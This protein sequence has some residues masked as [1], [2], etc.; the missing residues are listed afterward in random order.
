MNKLFLIGFVALIVLAGFFVF[1][2]TITGQGVVVNAINCTETDGG[3][4]YLNQGSILGTFS[5]N[6]TNGTQSWT[7]IV[8]DT[9]INNVTLSEGVCGSSVSS[10][11][12]NLAGVFSVDCS[13]PNSAYGCVNGAC[14][15]VGT[16]RTNATLRAD[17]IVSNLVY[18]YVSNGTVT[19]NGTNLTSYRVFVNATIRNVGNV[20]AVA[21]STRMMLSKVGEPPRIST[22]SVS[23]PTLGVGQST[24]VSGILT[25]LKGLNLLQADADSSN[26]IVE[27]NEAN[28]VRVVNVTLP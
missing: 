27:S 9:C 16:N 13:V 24:V 1:A 8:S 17:L 28:N 15:L 4:N 22:Q 20:T 6:T 26:V 18:A 25:G 5:W 11:Y 12:S 23:T 14:R 2:Q 10:S 7:G 19:Y 3:L 21:S